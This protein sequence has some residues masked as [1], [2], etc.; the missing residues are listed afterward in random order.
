MATQRGPPPPLPSAT[1]SAHW[2]LVTQP[3]PPRPATAVDGGV[4]R[5]ARCAASQSGAT[6]GREKIWPHLGGASRSQPRRA[7]A[8]GWAAKNPVREGQAR[9]TASRQPPATG[10]WRQTIA[11]TVAPPS[12]GRMMQAETSSAICGG[13]RRGSAS[14]MR[15]AIPTRG[16][17]RLLPSSPITLLPHSPA[18]RNVGCFL[19]HGHAFRMGVG[20]EGDWCEASRLFWAP[21]YTRA[22]EDHCRP[23]PSPQATH[24]GAHAHSNSGRVAGTA[25]CTVHTVS[26][27]PRGGRR[28]AYCTTATTPPRAGSHVVHVTGGGG[29][30]PLAARPRTRFQQTG[31]TGHPCSQQSEREVGAMVPT[32]GWRGP[33]A[34]W[35]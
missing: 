9:P 20:R 15:P 28:G 11:L 8:A 25:V 5:G 3:P 10:R 26:T 27:P 4:P 2:G 17:C 12:R 35:L 34:R 6:R 19:A 33:S 7:G 14:G 22:G 31:T 24:G 32:A 13:G 30:P 1:P 16:C 21:A 18:V 23:L 29:G